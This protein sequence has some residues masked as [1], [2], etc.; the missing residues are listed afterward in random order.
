VDGLPVDVATGVYY[1]WAKVDNGS[2]QKMVMSIGWN[3]FYKNEKK[4]MVSG[5]SDKQLSLPNRLFFM[6]ASVK[7][8]FFS[9]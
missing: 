8:V 9:R 7:K 4:S 1:G 6:L 5:G 2:L 3:P